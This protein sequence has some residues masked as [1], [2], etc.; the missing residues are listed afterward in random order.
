MKPQFTGEKNLLRLESQKDEEMEGL[1]EKRY[2]P[3]HPNIL[4]MGVPKGESK[5]GQIAAE[6]IKH[7]IGLQVITAPVL[8]E[9][10]R[11]SAPAL[12]ACLCAWFCRKYIKP[13]WP[14][15]PAT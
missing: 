13:L 1:T 10:G 2:G 8:G 12:Q 3:K 5:D 9:P 11:N 4:R 7:F 6:E 15:H 14:S